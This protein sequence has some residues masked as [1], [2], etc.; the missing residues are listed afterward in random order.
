LRRGNP[1]AA[2][3][4]D[5]GGSRAVRGVIDGLPEAVPAPGG[6]LSGPAASDGLDARAEDSTA[7]R[8]GDALPYRP[9][10]MAADHLIRRASSDI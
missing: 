6:A 2:H 10:G 7:I 1:L 9:H 4:P 5:P 8:V 3:R